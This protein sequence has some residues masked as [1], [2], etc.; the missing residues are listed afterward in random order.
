MIRVYP[1]VYT[2]AFGY[3][4][5][6][7]PL[8]E[9]SGIALETLIV[10]GAGDAVMTS[11]WRKGALVKN[12]TS[13]KPGTAI[14]TFNAAGVYDGHAAVYVSQDTMGI[15]VYDQYV[16]S[17]HPKAVGP[18]VLGWGARG[19]SNNGNNFYVIE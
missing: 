18:R 13:I 6:G 16:T 19:H 1:R 5:L 8:I 7:T 3:T 4:S 12:N 9:C 2:L 15:Q 14:A 10:M 17:G 11:H